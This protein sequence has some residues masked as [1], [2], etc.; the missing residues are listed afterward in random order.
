MATRPDSR[1][2]ASARDDTKGIPQVATE[3]WEL[4]VTYARQE[5]VDPLKGLGQFIGYGLGGAI[6]WGIAIVL[7]LVAG[8]RFLQTE[9]SAFDDSLS[10]AP[11]LI[12][13][14]VGVLIIG[15]SVARVSK[16]KGPGA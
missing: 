15:L 6:A 3:L 11:Y 12:V 9:T 5:T 4:T 8:L 14:V 2:A 7:F 16:R 10:W 1:D 13:C